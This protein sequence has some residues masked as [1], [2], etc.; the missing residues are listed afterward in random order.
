M[1]GPECFV[2]VEETEPI[3]AIAA[4]MPTGAAA[5]ALKANH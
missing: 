4:V 2:S 1:E 5:P 3:A